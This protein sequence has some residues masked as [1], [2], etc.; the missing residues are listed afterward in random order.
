MQ[1]LLL[2]IVATSTINT[3]RFT[4]S[5]NQRFNASDEAYYWAQEVERNCLLLKTNLSPKCI[6]SNY[7]HPSSN[8][9]NSTTCL[10]CSSSKK[11]MMRQR[12]QNLV[13]EK[14]MCSTYITQKNRQRHPWIYRQRLP[15]NSILF[16]CLLPYTRFKLLDLNYAGDSHW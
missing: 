11:I 4:L 6:I 8:F 15:V 14:K 10:Y 7:Q 2:L 16:L 1:Q 5:L 3:K 9:K 12:R 13:K